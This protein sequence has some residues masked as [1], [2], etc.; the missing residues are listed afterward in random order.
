MRQRFPLVSAL[1]FRYRRMIPLAN[2]KLTF[3]ERI[4]YITRHDDFVLRSHRAVS[5][6]V[7]PFLKDYKGWGCRRRAGQTENELGYLVQINFKQRF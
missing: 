5:P 2:H 4:G 1:E 3:D 6:Q 7:A